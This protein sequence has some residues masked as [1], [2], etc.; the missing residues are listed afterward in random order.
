MII[1]PRFHRILVPLQL[2][3]PGARAGLLH[4]PRPESLQLVCAVFHPSWGPSLGG[5]GLCPET[6]PLRLA[7]VRLAFGEAARAPG[8]P[9]AAPLLSRSSLLPGVAGGAGAAAARPPWGLVETGSRSVSGPQIPRRR[10]R[11]LASSPEAKW[12]RLEGGHATAGVRCV[13]SGIQGSA[14]R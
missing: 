7:P 6:L 9:L 12:P 1:Q 11:Q 14:Q 5:A 8:Q 10:R 3:P 2:R 4:D 13:L